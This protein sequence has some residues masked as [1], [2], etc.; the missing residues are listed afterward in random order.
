MFAPQIEL[1]IGIETAR[2]N[3][4]SLS[5]LLFGLTIRDLG[6]EPVA[7]HFKPTS[8]H[9][10]NCSFRPQF[11]YL[12]R[13]HLC[14]DAFNGSGLSERGSANVEAACPQIQ[15]AI[16]ELEKDHNNGCALAC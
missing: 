3:D 15:N 12:K 14:M 5:F 6:P 8:I 11:C 9:T 1:E 10:L 4:Y 7:C 2:W 16:A 13:P